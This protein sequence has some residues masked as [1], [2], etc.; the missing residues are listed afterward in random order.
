MSAAATGRVRASPYARRLARQRSI[1]L[2]QVSGS[3]PGGRIVAADIVAFAPPAAAPGTAG[4]VGTVSAIATRIEFGPLTTVLDRF[5]SPEARFELEDVLLR[6]AG[7]ALD[8]VPEATPLDG[9][10]VALEWRR[11][12]AP[13][14]VVLDHIRKTSLA[15]LRTRR[16][17]AM[18]ATTDQAHEP[19][20]LT[21]RLMRAEAIRPVLLPLL[22]GRVLRL[23]V[24][25]GPQ[26]GEALLVF[27]A[28][29]VAEDVAAQLLERF[30][31]YVEVPLLLLA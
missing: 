18:A 29:L 27:D 15:P 19:A 30:R 23:V 2:E 20:S 8:D 24:I 12:G 11:D 6:A 13:R 26:L 7:C 10:P 14:Q 22:P 1:G 3:G 25:A 17:A 31:G 16:L 21:L 5:G 9:A 4:T 28:G